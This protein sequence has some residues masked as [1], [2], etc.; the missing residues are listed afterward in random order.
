MYLRLRKIPKN[1]TSMISIS[2]WTV[3]GSLHVLCVVLSCTQYMRYYAFVY[4]NSSHLG[5]MIMRMRRSCA[6][7]R[8][9]KLNGNTNDSN[10]F[11]NF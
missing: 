11:Y 10:E 6:I 5:L 4:S 2:H 8:R 1:L 9:N 3:D 7:I